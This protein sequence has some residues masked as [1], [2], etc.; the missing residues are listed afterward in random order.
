MVTV[1][2]AATEIHKM[3]QIVSIKALLRGKTP[4]VRVRRLRASGHR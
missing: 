1:E 4:G 2:K 3:E